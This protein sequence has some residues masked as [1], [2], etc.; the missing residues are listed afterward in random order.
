[1]A[2]GGIP[3]KASWIPTAQ[4]CVAKRALQSCRGPVT[5]L[6]VSLFDD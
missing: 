3:C 2:L 1:M 4:K 6:N 5:S